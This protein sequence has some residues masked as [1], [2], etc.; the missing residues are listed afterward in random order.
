MSEEDATLETEEQQQDEDGEADVKDDKAAA[1]KSAAKKGKSNR[2]KAAKAAKQAKAAKKVT[3]STTPPPKLLKKTDEDG[4]DGSKEPEEQKE[5]EEKPSAKPD[6]KAEKEEPKKAKKGEKKDEKEEKKMTKEEM[7]KADTGLN[8]YRICTGVLTSRPLAKDVKIG[9]FSLQAYGRELIK[10]TELEFTIG[11]RYG[12]IGANGSGK[13]SLLK[14]LAHREVPIPKHIDIFHLDEEAEPS[15]RTALQAVID[16]AQKEVERLEKESEALMETEEGAGSDA[17]MDIEERLEELNP[18]TFETRAGKLLFGLGFSNEM[19]SKKTKDLSG[20]WRM[21]VALARALFV[22]PSL[23]LLD[24]PTNHLDLEACVWLEDYLSRY[25]RCLVV[26]SHSQDFLNGVCTNIIHLTPKRKLQVYTGNY[27][28]FIKTKA[29]NET[30]QMKK[31]KKEQDD[32]KHIKQFI[33]SAGT[34]ANLV[35]QAKSKQKILD[36]ME[37]VGLT[38]KVENKASFKFYFNQCDKL[39]PPVLVFDNVGF[40]YNGT[41]ERGVLYRKLNLGVDM[42]SRIALVGPNGAGK[43]TLLKLMADELTPTEGMIRKHP[44]LVI[45]R[46]HQHSNDQLDNDLTPLDYMAKQFPDKKYEVETWRQILGRYGISGYQ[47]TVKIGT[48]SDGIKSRLVF[49]FL[50]TSN[51]SLLLLD[52]PT[53][54][55][56]MECIDSLALAINEYNGGLV[57][58]SHDFR[59]LQQ[60]AKEIWVCDYNTIK[61]WKGDIKSYKASLLKKMKE[62]QTIV[63]T[64]E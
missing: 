36:K 15:D 60:V 28:T 57:L 6:K 52:E 59:L 43:S 16:E 51:P 25:D 10:D 1:K 24:E 32:I 31:W 27:D 62:R 45:A 35:R 44:S 37:A 29:E 12:L 13:S 14:C 33:A 34:Y 53:N 7:K 3:K 38:E 2:A 41:M 22:K 61:P 18:A 48:L 46:Y 8:S 55:L 23:L 54:H 58:V 26:I 17:V 64:D 42:D 50:A 4:E 56:D 5:E 30:N 9:Q 20:G 40:S 49:C 21:R 47:Q 39:P 11:R 63:L 19:M